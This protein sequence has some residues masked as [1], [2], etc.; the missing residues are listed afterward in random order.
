MDFVYFKW[1]SLYKISWWKRELNV[2][3]TRKL[4]FFLMFVSIF[5]YRTFT[6]TA[7]MWRQRWH[8]F[9]LA[10]TKCAHLI[11]AR[12]RLSSSV[13]GVPIFEFISCS[14][15]I[16][17]LYRCRSLLKSLQNIDKQMR[18]PFRKANTDMRALH[19]PFKYKLNS[20]TENKKKMNTFFRV[21][22]LV[23]GAVFDMC[24]TQWK[25]SA[26]FLMRQRNFLHIQPYESAI[27][28]KFYCFFFLSFN[29][30]CV[31]VSVSCSAINFNE[32]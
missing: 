17:C 16:N 9:Q 30:V 31:S 12:Q 11:S 2:V 8:F 29:F 28:L 32:I 20:E 23:A 15:F 7:I 6:S 10:I 1:K 5:F 21:V 3:F 27:A 25:K 24:T 19:E 26:S 14:L 4:T 18:K 13:F 22:S